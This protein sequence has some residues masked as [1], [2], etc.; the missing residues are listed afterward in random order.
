VNAHGGRV[1]LESTPNIGTTVTV[2]MPLER[3]RAQMREAS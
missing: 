3:A 1:T 2:I